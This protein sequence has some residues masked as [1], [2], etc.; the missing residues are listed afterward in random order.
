MSSLI[1]EIQWRDFMSK[2]PIQLMAMKGSEVYDGEEY[3][4]VFIP[5]VREDKIVADNIRTQGEYLAQRSNSVRGQVN[6][7]TCDC[8]FE[9]K[10]PFGLQSH[11][12]VHAALVEA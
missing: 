3:V 6:E 8:G 1:P 7:L 12:R 5:L 11:Q 9:A 2:T 4:G 10:S